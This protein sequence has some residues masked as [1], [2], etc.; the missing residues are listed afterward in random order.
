MRSGA[1]Q[2]SVN[3]AALGSP[4]RA[5]MS[6]VPDQEA[7]EPKSSAGRKPRSRKPTSA[8]RKSIASQGAAPTKVTAEIAARETVGG[9]G[10]RGRGRPPGV[11]PTVSTAQPSINQRDLGTK[12]L[13]TYFRQT[14]NSTLSTTADS[15]DL[16][17]LAC[18]G[19]PHHLDGSLYGQTA[20]K[21]CL[22]IL[23]GEHNW[24][25]LLLL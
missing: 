9:G 25:S 20:D 24:D 5:V 19:D 12:E 6:E 16:L 13:A 8:A 10:R 11:Y 18:Q 4:T 15:P 22:H 1:L 21:F 17:C 2:A 3:A 23:T 7:V 14:C